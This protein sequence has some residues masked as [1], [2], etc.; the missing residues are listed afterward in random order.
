VTAQCR[1]RSR[2]LRDRYL[3]ATSAIVGVRSAAATNAPA[4]TALAPV[5]AGGRGCG[6]PA[7][8]VRRPQRAA[9]RAV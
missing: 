7:A 8:A 2:S 3:A 9:G 5:H 6:A 4:E 1:S